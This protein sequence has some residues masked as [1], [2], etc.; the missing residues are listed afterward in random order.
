MIYY[1]TY[2]MIMDYNI[3]LITAWWNWIQCGIHIN[4]KPKYVD[5]NMTSGKEN[6]ASKSWH[7]IKFIRKLNQ[8]RDRY[9][10]ANN[11]TPMKWH[12]NLYV[13]FVVA[14]SA[15]IG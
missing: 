2:S 1:T 7:G 6:I 13:E 5:K 12:Y 4:I 10:S 8:G 11:F 15:F 3:C 9:G 14:A